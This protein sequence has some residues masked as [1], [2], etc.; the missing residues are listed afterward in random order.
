MTQPQSPNSPT[1]TYRL[2]PTG[3]TLLINQKQ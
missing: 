3:H 2:T 1:Q